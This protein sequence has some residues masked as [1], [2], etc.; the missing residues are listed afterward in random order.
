MRKFYFSFIYFLILGCQ[1]EAPKEL[2]KATKENDHNF[3]LF[4]KSFQKK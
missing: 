1:S 4:Q 3:S 2:F